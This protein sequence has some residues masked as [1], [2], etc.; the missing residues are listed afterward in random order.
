MIVIFIMQMVDDMDCMKILNL[1]DFLVLGQELNN[2]SV[3]MIIYLLN[4]FIIFVII[5]E[6]LKIVF[7][8]H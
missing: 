1:K 5:M 7:I 4:S 2:K 6:S 8:I 3:I